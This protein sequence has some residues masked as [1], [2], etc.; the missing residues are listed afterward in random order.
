[1]RATAETKKTQLITDFIETRR[2]VLDAAAALPPA[3]QDEVF[4]G[5]WSVKDLLAHLAGWD[6]ANREAAEAVLAGRLP[7]FYAY[8]DHDWRTYNARLVAQYRR[9]DF[10]ALRALVEE[11]HRALVEYLQA[12]PA[13]AF[14]KDTGVRFKGYKNTVARL[15]QSEVRDEK[16]HCVQVREFKDRNNL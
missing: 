5:V 11:T 15:I 8:H 16:T 7:A 4:L 6:V 12:I 2:A 14:E 3:A 10:A 9:E 1:M 13:A